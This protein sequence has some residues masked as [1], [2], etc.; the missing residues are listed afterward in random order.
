MPKNKYNDSVAAPRGSAPEARL[1][2]TPEE[3]GRF[4]RE[5]GKN[6]QETAEKGGA[7]LIV[8]GARQQRQLLIRDFED[9]HKFQRG[10]HLCDG[11]RHVR[12]DRAG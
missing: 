5:K 9:V 7:G 11:G 1:K 3:K 4:M 12:C 8:G 6:T 2:K 10:F